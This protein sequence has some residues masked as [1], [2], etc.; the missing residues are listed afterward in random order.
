MSDI[1]ILGEP[2]GSAAKIAASAPL[3]GR[4][5]PRQGLFGEKLIETRPEVQD[6]RRPKLPRSLI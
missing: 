4:R 1:S 2:G 5:I 6:L 3:F